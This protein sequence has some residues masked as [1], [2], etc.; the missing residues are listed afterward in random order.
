MPDL[1]EGAGVE[2]DRTVLFADISGSTRLY[3]ERGDEAARALLLKCLG[4]MANLVTG[5]G[6]CVIERIGDE[7]LCTFP[8]PV[9][10]AA[11]AALVHETVSGGG[12][13]MRVRIGF[14]HGPVIESDGRIFGTTVQIAARLASLAKAGQTITSKETVELLSEG[15]QLSS[16]YF[17]T[18]VLK[19]RTG[20]LDVYELPW[21]LDVTIKGYAP[22]SRSPHVR[23]TTAIE[24]EYAG[25]S[26]RVDALNPRIEI[27]RNPACDLRVEGN[28]VSAL[29]AII[30]WNRGQTH[31]EDVS[32]NGTGV[33]PEQGAASRI[34]HARAAL[35]GTGELHLGVEG[36][37]TLI[38]FRCVDE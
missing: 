29:H 2:R 11:A 38:R 13:R 16:R 22:V 31:V 7:L 12:E 33:C 30:T 17:D 34:L 8:D 28:F 19:G 3:E 14:L 9:R 20:E 4:I 10:A 27:G 36:E 35:T 15:D 18:V 1:S 24:V 26:L 21:S 23:R 25:E 32:T 5:A 37:S 6:G